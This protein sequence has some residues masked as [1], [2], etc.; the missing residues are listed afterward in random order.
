MKN[1]LPIGRHLGRGKIPFPRP[2]LILAT[3]CA[4]WFFCGETA[5]AQLEHG[6][7]NW[8]RDL[9]SIQKSFKSSLTHD[10]DKDKE[11]EYGSSEELLS[12]SSRYYPLSGI[13]VLPGGI[14]RTYGYLVVIYVPEDT[15]GREKHWIAYAWP[16]EYGKTGFHTFVATEVEI[17]DQWKNLAGADLPRFSGPQTVPPA[18]SAFEGDPFK[19][20]TFIPAAYM[21]REWNWQACYSDHS[22]HFLKSG[23]VIIFIVVAGFLLFILTMVAWVRERRGPRPPPSSRMIP[24][25]R[26]AVAGLLVVL[27]L[28]FSVTEI[29]DYASSRMSMD[30]EPSFLRASVSLV[31]LFLG[32]SEI[33][34]RRSAYGFAAAGVAFLLLGL[35]GGYLTGHLTGGAGIA[36]LVIPVFLVWSL[37]ALAAG[38]A[39]RSQPIE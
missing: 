9:A 6:I 17:G 29:M 27:L 7:K 25:W 35:D 22:L 3:A 10:V 20:G 2:A 38:F 16:W 24:G 34:G 33:L 31:A 11:G 18:D 4:S 8:M 15:D 37:L 39:R 13:E 21:D 26:G 32:I 28:P 23:R 19:E 12:E 5:F 14:L 1:S 36:T 30:Y